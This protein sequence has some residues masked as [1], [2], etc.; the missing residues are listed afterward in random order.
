M[1]VV[2][3]H[4]GQG[5]CGVVGREGAVDAFGGSFGR[6][7]GAGQDR[8]PEPGA[9]T[10]APTSS[11]TTTRA[12]PPALRPDPRHLERLRPAR[13]AEN[14]RHLPHRACNPCPVRAACTTRKTGGRQLTIHRRE[15][16]EI[17]TELRAVQGTQAWQD[18]YKRR[19][20]IEG[21]M[22]QAVAVTGVRR[23]RYRGLPKVQL[24][25]RIAATAINLVRLDAYFTEHPLDRGRT[26]HLARLDLTLAA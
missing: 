16:H 4:V 1:S 21:T 3:G 9:A 6:F 26:S 18:R 11:S 25:H 24:E 7:D 20:G 8:R 23:A 10:P 13:R 15:I 2:G 17:Q 22:H 14:R 19:S 12:P 5:L